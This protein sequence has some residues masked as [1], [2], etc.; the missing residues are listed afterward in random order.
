MAH[1][2]LTDVGVEF[3]IH[4]ANSRSLQLQVFSAL[5]G[6]LARHS[7][8]VFVRALNGVNL[9]IEEGDRIGI[10]GHNGAGKTT[11]LR[12]LAGVYEPTQG[13]LS[14]DGRLSSFTDITLG[15]DPE[16]TG[17]DNIIFRCVFMGL[18]FTEARRLSPSIEEFSELGEFLRLPVRTYSTGMFLRLAFAISTS[19]EPEIVVMD[20][21]IG[22]G[23]A[24]FLEKAKARL[25][26]L[27]TRVKI[28][29][30]A[31]HDSSLMAS[32]CNKI[33]WLDHGE[34]RKI[35]PFDEVY[36]DYLEANKS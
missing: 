11:L 27:L 18:T 30:V 22:A 14:V 9:D 4:N 25:A 34:V 28:L 24:R 29:V 10:V 23:D 20:E 31:T 5:G 12:V 36:P 16:A 19:I 1:I 26:D 7:H 15:M 21:M 35:G 6:K 32:L 33:V 2:K 8:A 17:L 3:P 13:A